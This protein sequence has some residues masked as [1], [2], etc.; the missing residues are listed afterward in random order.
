M[1]KKNN[2]PVSNPKPKTKK[3]KDKVSVA[4]T[5]VYTIIIIGVIGLVFGLVLTFTMLRNK[6]DLNVDE[7]VSKQSSQ[8]YD[9]DNELIS[10]IG[11][12]KRQNVSYDDIPNNLIDAFVATEDSRFFTHP[13]FDISRFSKAIIENLKS[14]SFAQGGSTFTMQLVKN[15]Y[16]VD[17]EAAIG[18]SK[19]VERK[20]QEIALSL[21]LEKNVSKK[22]IFELYLN[23]LNF[24]GSGNIRGVQ[25]AAQY[26]Y[27]KDVQELSLPESAL[28]AGVINA[29]NAFNPHNN[30]EKATNRR[31][32][33]LYLMNR[34]GYISDLEY[35]TAKSIKVEDLLVE[36]YSSNVKG[37][38]TP[39][40]AYI[41][42]VIAE[43]IR[44]TGY[45]PTVTPMRI[46]TS[47]DPYVQSIMDDI[48]AENVD[49]YFEYPDELFE[50]ASICINNSNGEINGILGGRSYADGGQLLLNHATEQFNQPGSSIKPMLD[51]ALAFENLGWATSH[52]VLDR[53]IMWAGTDFLISNANGRY[54]GQVTL[55]DAVGNSLNTPAVQ[56]LQEVVDKKSS[57]Y[58]VEYM[59]N[60]GFDQV[61]TDDFNV[62]YGIGGSTLAASVKQMASAQTT[63][64]NGGVHVPAH[65]IRR[66]EFLSG[67]EPVTPDYKGKQAL[68]EEA[69]FLT[70][71]LLY[72]NVYGPY[73]NLMQIL[74][75]DYAVYAKT[76]TTD[77]G[78]AG[79]QYG[80]P[81]GAGK[82]GWMIGSTSEYTT[83]TWIGYERAIKDKNTYLSNN[84]YLR[85]I[86]GKIT[87]MLLDA[88]VDSNGEPKKI[89]KPQGVT[90]ISH[91]LGTFPYV[92]PIEGMDEKYLAEGY[93]KSSD[94]KLV[95]PKEIHIEEF[96][97]EVKANLNPITKEISL[98]WP[99][100]PDE[101]KLKV[102]EEE[103]DISLKRNDGSVIKEATGKRLFDYSWIYGP[104]RYKA[105]IKRSDV[106][107]KLVS[108]TTISSETENKVE[109]IDYTFGDK[110]E[111][112][113]YYAY[114]NKDV[115]SN[116]SCVEISIK[117]EE[118]SISIPKSTD[119][120]EDIKKWADNLNLNLNYVTKPTTDASLLNKSVI[121]D[122]SNQ[123]I[124]GQNIKM[125]QS[126]VAKAKW[127]CTTYVDQ[128]INLSIVKTGEIIAGQS[129]TFSV[130]SDVNGLDSNKFTWEITSDLT[131]VPFTNTGTS[132]T[133]DIP[134]GVTKLHVKVSYSKDGA[135]ASTSEDFD[136]SKSEA[137]ELQ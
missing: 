128:E 86:Q 133:Y 94:A 44:L 120:L 46:Y 111:V 15:T 93:I 53:P 62:Q 88:T 96:K 115:K 12:V 51:Y 99:K 102:A 134:D 50:V 14:R 136:V 82:D 87:N 121:T 13:G 49:G 116:K 7:F 41:D 39:Y 77:W 81:V 65:T 5:V 45:D 3:K 85:N 21:E 97:G 2:K 112:C 123:E 60:L 83:C 31:N 59:N 37:E 119:K 89:A 78:T 20:V 17:D 19:S 80:I 124:N 90:Q 122:E 24:G 70:T 68:S 129:A 32:Q 98:S 105:D 64:L 104:V 100:Y 22:T 25:K 54:D 95:N 126:Q 131:S 79:K 91:I 29:P 35:E 106:T 42:E 107:G 26:Y 33:V 130:N 52:V 55:K 75:D 34:H 63:L 58:V 118:I 38:G 108:E 66:I 69:A 110:I 109:K 125:K 113:G 23:K 36:P 72:S 47:M 117:D 30:L 73:A 67:K 43:T 10:E 114:D 127:T 132:I 57:A 4:C 103:M 9:R 40:Q 71:E 137:E 92:S 8:I 61:N 6:P 74:R 27:G 48:Q 16:F 56:T 76:G 84:K 101:S 18:A 135:N 28:L 1:I 11:S